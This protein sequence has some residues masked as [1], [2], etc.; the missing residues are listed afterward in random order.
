MNFN[1][2][3]EMTDKSVKALATIINTMRSLTSI[4]LKFSFCFKLKKASIKHI[5]TILR[6]S[7]RLHSLTLDLSDMIGMHDDDLVILT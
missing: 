6:C 3:V 5:S 2:S 4:K 1:Q 7:Q